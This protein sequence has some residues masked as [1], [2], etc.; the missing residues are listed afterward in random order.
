MTRKSDIN[1]E[2]L[3]R[4]FTR[5]LIEATGDRTAKY[6]SDDELDEVQRLLK[7]AVAKN[8]GAVASVAAGEADIVE[9][10]PQQLPAGDAL[11]LSFDSGQRLDRET[12]LPKA[13]TTV[14]AAVVVS[15]KS[16]P[17]FSDRIGHRPSVGSQK[18]PKWRWPTA[19]AAS[20]A[21]LI[22]GFMHSSPTL[23]PTA[24]PN[25]LPSTPQV[26]EVPP[27]QVNNASADSLRQAAAANIEQLI[28]RL[29]EAEEHGDIQSN[30]A[31]VKLDDPV[32]LFE[33]G[34]R[35]ITRNGVPLNSGLGI[36]YFAAASRKRYEPAEAMLGALLYEGKIVKQQK[37]FGLALLTAAVNSASG[38]EEWAWIRS[39]Y[40]EALI[41]ATKAEEAEAVRLAVEWRAKDPHSPVLD[42]SPP[43]PSRAPGLTPQGSGVSPRI[44]VPAGSKR[45]QGDNLIRD[46][47]DTVPTGTTVPSG[48]RPPSE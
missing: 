10:R 21:L 1:A 42:G 4:N 46:S 12:G 37:V 38:V 9:T 45:G 43:I 23:E 33:L 30:D 48:A 2:R 29:A 18:R 41:T 22:A 20:L 3:D 27:S 31:G 8:I 16:A 6:F 7:R 26:V 40:E 44:A 13:A 28:T 47:F 17:L 32:S 25:I 36:K 14:P 11:I 5:K 15:Y 34:K 35:Y 19:I 39:T 24:S